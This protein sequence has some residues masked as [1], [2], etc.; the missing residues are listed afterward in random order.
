[1]KEFKGER[2]DGQRCLSGLAGWLSG[3]GV[4]LSDDLESVWTLSSWS[5][6]CGF[7]LENVN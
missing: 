6:G 5:L 1:M 2:S 4:V 7:A 3:C